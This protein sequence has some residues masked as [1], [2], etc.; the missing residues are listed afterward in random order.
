MTRQSRASLSVIP[1]PS[2]VIPASSYVIP[3]QA[4]IHLFPLSL[5]GAQRRGNP[6][7]RGD[8]LLLYSRV[9]AWRKVKYVPLLIIIFH[10]K[11]IFKTFMV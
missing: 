1:A 4:G 3:A 7:I 10:K 11:R 5:R 9:Y 6:V 2:F 8:I